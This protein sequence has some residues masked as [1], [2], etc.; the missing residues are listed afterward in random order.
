MRIISNNCTF[1]QLFPS[2]VNTDSLIV[3]LI[4]AWLTQCQCLCMSFVLEPVGVC[5]YV[6]VCLVCAEGDT[7]WRLQAPSLPY[8]M[9]SPSANEN[10]PT[11]IQTDKPAQANYYLTHC[12]DYK[13]ILCLTKRRW[14][15]LRHRLTKETD[16]CEVTKEIF[17]LH[18]ELFDAFMHD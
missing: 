12:A 13:I 17:L 7:E 9:T 14:I 5:V 8:R 3:A 2:S 15:L 6:C 10:S 18:T 16:V 4:C 1:C 11:F